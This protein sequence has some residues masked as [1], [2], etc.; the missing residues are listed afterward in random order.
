[1]TARNEEAMTMVD[2][3]AEEMLRLIED[4]FAV[5]KTVSSYEV[6]CLARFHTLGQD[7]ERGVRY[8]KDGV[9]DKAALTRALADAVIEGF[10][11]KSEILAF[12]RTA[13]SHR[14]VYLS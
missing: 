6:R 10:D 4:V 11:R 7:G 14:N 9:Y 3:S 13:C 5:R 8:L 1:M 2:L 12:H